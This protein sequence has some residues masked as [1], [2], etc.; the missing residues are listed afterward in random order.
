VQLLNVKLVGALRNQ[1]VNSLSCE[2][3]HYT[4]NTASMSTDDKTLGIEPLTQMITNTILISSKEEP[5]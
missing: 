1:K 2:L 4:Y 3:L 5:R